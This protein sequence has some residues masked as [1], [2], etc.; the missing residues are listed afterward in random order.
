M[1]PF[2]AM[3]KFQQFA[4]NPMGTL[5]DQF[6]QSQYAQMRAQNPQ[7]FQQVQQM[8]SGKDRNQLLEMAG[9]MAGER[10]TTLKDF[11]AQYGVSV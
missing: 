7:R 1:N 4:Q 9:N 3:G 10:G 11:A 2:Q 8:L 5:T 6:I